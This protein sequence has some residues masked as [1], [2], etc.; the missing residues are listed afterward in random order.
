M[1]NLAPPIMNIAIFL[2]SFLHLI[3]ANSYPIQVC[4]RLGYGETVLGVVTVVLVI[5]VSA[6]DAQLKGVSYSS[7]AL[8]GAGIWTA[9]V[10]IVVGAITV[11]AAKKKQRKWVRLQSWE[12][13]ISIFA[14]SIY[15]TISATVF[16]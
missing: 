9:I 4:C 15:L 13:S 14:C 11:C 16:T 10:F 1:Q 12:G 3:H 7:S 2:S 6:L 8:T 5:I